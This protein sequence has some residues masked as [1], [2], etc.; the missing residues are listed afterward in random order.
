MPKSNV[1]QK[2]VTTQLWLWR[3]RAHS[4]LANRGYRLFWSETA[5]TFHDWSVL[6]RL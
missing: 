5:K 2:R 6:F 4:R 1:L 3:R